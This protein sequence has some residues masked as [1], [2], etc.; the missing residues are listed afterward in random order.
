MD[1]EHLLL[2]LKRSLFEW[3][4]FLPLKPMVE[5][6]INQQRAT[7]NESIFD[8]NVIEFQSQLVKY[9]VSSQIFEKFPPCT[10][11]TTSFIKKFLL[12][13]ESAQ[14]EG[15]DSFYEYVSSSEAKYKRGDNYFKSYFDEQGNHLV[16]LVEKSE[17]ICDGTTGLR[18]WQAGK[19]LFTWIIENLYHLPQAEQYSILELGSGVGYTG[20]C[21]FNDKRCTPRRI[22]LTDHHTSVLE[23][24][25]QNVIANLGIP[26]TKYH[27]T[28]E[29]HTYSD[30]KNVMFPKTFTSDC[31]ERTLVIDSLDWE[32]FVDRESNHFMY[33]CD[34]VIGADI[35]FDVSVI[36]H[37]VNVIVKFLTSLG[38][39]KVILA[40]CLRNEA[41]D[42]FFVNSLKQHNVMVEKQTHNV[43]DLPL[44]LYIIQK[45]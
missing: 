29:K 18:T 6:F 42:I 11:S 19:F 26:K 5:T 17:L 21:I 33:S 10:K 12:V 22:T 28:P 13:F 16:S 7:A 45:Q 36:P 30:E 39:K 2:Y 32:H 4:S 25:H 9:T 15:H 38:T 24:L 8:Q 14:I 20:L 44:H 27:I 3:N 34:I 40:N 35:V 31:G 1:E 43:D 23:A 37:L 41:T